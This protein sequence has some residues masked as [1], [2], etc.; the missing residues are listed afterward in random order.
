[1]L[2]DLFL[3]FRQL[4]KSPLVTLAAVTSLALA[5]G[6][7]TALFSIFDRLVVRPHTFRDPDTLVRVWTNDPARNIVAPGISWPRFELLRDHQT[8]FAHFAASTFAGLGYTR[9]G[10]EPEQVQS[11]RVT[12]GF[13]PALGLEM[14]RG[15]NFLPE[16]DVPGA[17]PVVVLTHEF[18]QTRLGGREGAVGESILLNGTPHTIVGILPPRLSNP[19]STV[20]LFIT[21]TWEPPN[22]TPSQVQAGASYLQLTARLKPGVTFE[23][24]NLEVAALGRRYQ[25]E[26]ST[27]MDASSPIEIR[28]LTTEMGGNLLPTLRMLLG[29]VV[30][31]L[32]I[33]CANVSNLF[34]ARLSARQK[35]IA[36]RLSLGAT[37]AH[38]IR[39]FLIE[40]AVFAFIA[41]ALGVGLSYFALRL[42]E[43]LAV[44]Q[45]PANTR[46]ALSGFTLGFTALVG[47][48]TALGVGL[49]P[50]WQASR[51]GLADV[52]KDTAR[53]QPGGT[54]GGRF[55]AGLI[56]AEVGLAVVLLIGSALLLL[57]FTRLQ[58]TPAGLNP[59]GVAYAFLSLPAER[60]R[61]AMQQAEFHEQVIERLKSYPQVK[62]AA[63]AVGLPLGGI[64][65]APYTVN[66]QPIL[67]LPERPLVGLQ[68]VSAEFFQVHQ[69]PLREGRYFTSRDREG[70]PGV[71][72]IN[73]AFA[74]RLFPGESALG[75]SL[76]RGRDAE[77]IVEIVGVVADVRSQGL[78]TPP[79]D[80][81]YYSLL[82]M[83]RPAVNLF[84]RIDG[85]P[86]ALQALMRQAVAE[87]DRNQPIAFFNT[88]DNL[89]RANTGFQR[90]VAGLTG[91]FAGVALL[92]TAV[93]LYSVLAYTVGQRTGEIG[94]RMAIGAS[95]RDIVQLILG[96]G[97]RLVGAGLIVGLAAAAGSAWLIRSLLFGVEPFNALLYAAVTAVF[98]LI[99][100]AACLLPSLRAARIDPLVALR[101]E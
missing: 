66:G 56:V 42:V 41:T 63:A 58:G 50:A 49:A 86:A 88:M 69:I 97:L 95:R 38:L 70:A 48:V 6:A 90:L 53:G 71:C 18:W 75:K 60:Y 100:A 78:G 80:V 43:E 23:Q 85:D 24:A 1:M 14:A 15:R 28:T 68:F 32:L 72:I 29:A 17:A 19:F 33:A 26:F 9:D 10:G 93:G 81:I 74:K 37:R 59:T 55:R 4:R 67:P 61:T 94:I 13:F 3:A 40:S 39:Q 8:S 82:Q 98:L 46:F 92:L 76:R 73:E 51:I 5:L 101:S 31:V 57:S 54:R 77:V 99:A 91:I 47:V 83:G 11:L 89:V 16:E 2:S 22:L 84:A 52:L 36:V 20:L 87:V 27:R 21:R 30:A 44:N 62:A 45:L 25:Q 12:R 79:P 35:E 96:Q 64:P 65:I 7:N 34:L